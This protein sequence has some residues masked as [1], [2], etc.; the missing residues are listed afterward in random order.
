MIPD[1][2]RRVSA[3]HRESLRQ[4]AAPRRLKFAKRLLFRLFLGGLLS[5]GLSIPALVAT[6]PNKGT[7]PSQEQKSAARLEYD[8]LSAAGLAAQD[9]QRFGD[10]L[11]NFQAALLIAEREKW[12]Q[13]AARCLNLIGNVHNGSGDY[14][15]ALEFHQRGLKLREKL[16]NDGEIASS[17]YNVGNDYYGLRQYAEALDHYQRSLKL[18]EKVGNQAQIAWA[19]NNIGIVHRMLGQY[20]LARQSHQSALQIR[21]KLGD[22]HAVAVS[23]YNLG[24]VYSS[25]EQPDQALESHLRALRIRE[26]LGIDQDISAS[27]DNIGVIYYSLRRYDQ[28]LHYYQRSLKLEEKL[29]REAFIAYG[30]EKIGDVYFNLKQF[31]FALDSYKR[32]VT[33]WQNLG[34]ERDF[35]RIL[36]YV[37]G[38]YY[39][40]GDL[41]KA[42]DHYLRALKLNEKLDAEGAVASNQQDI[43]RTF[44]K[45]GLYEKAREY[46]QRA[47]KIW[48]KTGNE[49]ELAWCLVGM[50]A[51]LSP[52]EELSYYRRSLSIFEK[53]GDDRGIAG[54]LNNIGAVYQSRGQYDESMEF[55]QRS[56]ALWERIEDEAEIART[57]S[58][59]GDVFKSR[60]Q[61]DKALEHY[62][63][64]LQLREKIGNE[65]DI[66]VTLDTIGWNLAEEG[67]LE[68][69][70]EAYA[71][72][73][74][75]LES[76]S[77]QVRDPV[78]LGAF[79]AANQGSLYARFA[80]LR[81]R[82]GKPEA[83]LELVEGGR[84]RGL[85]QQV[86][87]SEKTL[88]RI[89]S[90]KDA[91][92]LQSAQDLVALKSGVVRVLK[93]SSAKKEEVEARGKEL[94]DARFNLARVKDELFLKYPD[95][96]M[97][98]GEKP[99]NAPQILAYARRH[100]DTVFVEYAEI[101][102]DLLM[103]T[104]DR[105]GIRAKE[106]RAAAPHKLVE[107]YLE[108]V[109][110]SD[111]RERELAKALFGLLVP[112]EAAE[113]GK[114]IVFV[115]DG[116][117][118]DLPFAALMD[119]G[120]K[121]LIEEHAVSTSLSLGLFLWQST[122]R[123]SE[124]GLLAIADPTGQGG[125]VVENPVRGG[126]GPLPGARE[127]GKAVVATLP[128]SLALTGKEANE[129]RVKEGAPKYAVLH[130]ACHGNL[131]VD[132]RHSALVLAKEA[133][134]AAE[135]GFLTA[136]EIWGMPLTANLAVLSACHTG[137][138]VNQGGEGL[139]GL[140]WA[141]RAAGVP[142]I[143]AS[144][145]QVDDAATSRI[146]VKFYEELKRG[147]R[148]DDALRTAM[149]AE[150][151]YPVTSGRP[152]SE[153]VSVPG[154]KPGQR[155]SNAFYWAAFQLI[156]DA[157]PLK[158]GK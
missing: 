102:D 67:R 20:E 126:F 28:A 32:A 147:A 123:E 144:K 53:L 157:E 75:L 55:L 45:L 103:F 108:A 16:G 42:L 3:R 151:N 40:L 72:A 146:M 156:G 118:A 96:Q 136:E 80:A 24:L 154:L 97:L 37:G 51:V 43:G 83:A 139:M 131:A 117:L 46:W 47:S 8:N 68:E 85:G 1:L 95:F 2:H 106:L 19:H 141:F 90:S 125:E 23:L 116:S 94:A 6:Q 35:A 59:I 74:E 88:A 9:Q 113:A 69:A 14:N 73:K 100:P 137:Q 66:A 70:E 86:D 155:R 152:R 54:C 4:E 26:K 127:E 17:L 38:A 34:S 62:Q 64:A 57:V 12:E 76:I 99:A 148:K 22:E 101:G 52:S 104:I 138:G 91:K 78:E 105:D 71:R 65:L 134:G 128:G 143:V 142:S 130:F 58:S 49:R 77:R 93:E 120:G 150:M 114:R 158:L 98:V 10:A 82:Q 110:T 29:G 31:R 129:G 133:E 18:R 111:A 11:K 92:V 15:K 7:P 135:D 13:E 153:P 41:E 27:L 25:L 132:P 89:L 109:Q 56:L 21:E 112:P 30:L 50:G 33:R 79:Q 39:T 84:L 81:I 61:V 48:E 5:S 63:R 124:G 87:L 44:F 145:W 122:P 60:G 119:S 140:T 107:D 121:R 149:L 36:G 115:P